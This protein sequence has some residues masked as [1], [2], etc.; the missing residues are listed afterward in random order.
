MVNVKNGYKTK[1]YERCRKMKKL[2][3]KIATVV[4]AVAMVTAMTTTAFAADAEYTVA[5]N[6]G[7][8][9]DEWNIDGEAMPKLEDGTYSQTFENV[10]KGTYEFKVATKGDWNAPNYNLEGEANSSGNASVTVDVDGST[11]IV[12][13][14]GTKAIVEVKAPAGGDTTGTT[15]DADTTPEADTTPVTGDSAAVVA[16]FAVAA[17]AGAM[18]VASRRQ[19]AN[20]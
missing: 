3:K 8:C 20:N 5:G 10:A 16:M 13:F 6:A 11:V 17:V 1:K 15:P 7:L 14:D 12:S 9:G 18:V 19:T 4:A 2:F